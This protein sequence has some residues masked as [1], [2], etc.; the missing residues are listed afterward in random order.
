MKAPDYTRKIAVLDA[1]I[2][3]AQAQRAELIH[4]RDALKEAP[5]AKR[6]KAKAPS[7]KRQGKAPVS[8][9]IK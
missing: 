5:V 7:K 9:L 2:K 8:R 4:K 1:K 6:P 3:L